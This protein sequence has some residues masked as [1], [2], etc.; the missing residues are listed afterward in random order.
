MD[1][2]IWSIYGQTATRRSVDRWEKAPGTSEA[3]LS[4]NHSLYMECIRMARIDKAKFDW[5]M[6]RQSTFMEDLEWRIQQT[7]DADSGHAF[8]TAVC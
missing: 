5:Q 8:I 2:S 4:V 3:M 7:L 6:K 1:E